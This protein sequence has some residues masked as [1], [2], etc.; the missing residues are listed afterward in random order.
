VGVGAG[1]D[2]KVDVGVS[3]GASAVWVA[4]MLAAIFV[5]RA[6]SSAWEGPQATKMTPVNKTKAMV[7]ICFGNF[8][9]FIFLT[10]FFLLKLGL[11]LLPNSVLS[12]N[13]YKNSSGLFDNDS[14]K[15]KRHLLTRWRGYAIIA[16]L[17][18]LGG[19][20]PDPG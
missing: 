1:V 5:A 14:F 17:T 16:K 9:C 11:Y 19:S 2:V 7:I 10:P 13:R 6:S 8:W 18:G 12:G 3:V 15:Q 20:S 4:K